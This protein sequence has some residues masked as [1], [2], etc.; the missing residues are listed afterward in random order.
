MQALPKDRP[1]VN[2][3]LLNKAAPLR[4]KLPKGRVLDGQMLTAFEEERY[5]VD[6]LLDRARKPSSRVAALN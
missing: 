2:E 4:I 6:T 3:V 5:R 1:N